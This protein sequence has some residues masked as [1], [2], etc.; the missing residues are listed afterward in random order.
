[1]K[2]FTPKTPAA[3]TAVFSSG[4]WTVTDA[5]GKTTT[6][7]DD[8]FRQLFE[9]DFYS[10]LSAAVVH[11]VGGIV[12]TTVHNGDVLTVIVTLTNTG[13]RTLF[14]VRCDLTVTGKTLGTDFTVS[15][16]RPNGCT[17][18]PGDT[19]VVTLAGY[20]VTA[21]DVAATHVAVGATVGSV[22]NTGTFVVASNLNA[23][24]HGAGGHSVPAA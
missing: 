4:T 12:V 19:Q 22:D 13:T 16:A 17:L 20:T 2:T 18:T 15:Y 5:A 23:D 14:G 9:P 3:F 1:M 10:A 11:K 6:Y 21:G 8:L 7:S 24:I